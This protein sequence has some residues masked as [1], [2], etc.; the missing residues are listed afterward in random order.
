LKT[1]VLDQ[2]LTYVT[3]FPTTIETPL[4]GLA[5]TIFNDFIWGPVRHFSPPEV[6]WTTCLAEWTS[7]RNASDM[8]GK[9]ITG[10]GQRLG[11]FDRLC[12]QEPTFTASS[13][14]DCCVI[15]DESRGKITLD[16]VTLN[17]CS[18]LALE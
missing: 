11:N 17:L 7:K 14:S 6:T 9:I 2:I 18:S 13:E 8:L 1:A 12:D 10:S 15:D 16:Q 4:L 3:Y 5:I